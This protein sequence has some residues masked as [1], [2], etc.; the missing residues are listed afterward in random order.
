MKL[1]G[2]KM[3]KLVEPV[4]YFHVNPVAYNDIGEQQNGENY[5]ITDAQ[6]FGMALVGLR[7]VMQLM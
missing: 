1:F 2:G 5:Y 6:H 4:G 3:I 7:S